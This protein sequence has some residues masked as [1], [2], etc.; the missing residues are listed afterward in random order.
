MEVQYGK[1]TQ[2]EAGGKRKFGSAGAGESAIQG[3]KMTVEPAFKAFKFNA[4]TKRTADAKFGRLV[5]MA[6]GAV[7]C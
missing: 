4:L 7:V 3:R 6:I 2:A 5:A 1:N